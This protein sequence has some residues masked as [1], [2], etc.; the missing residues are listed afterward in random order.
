MGRAA[1]V[2]TYALGAHPGSYLLNARGSW[3][4]TQLL[5]RIGAANAELVWSM[6]GGYWNRD[7]CAVRSW[8]ER[9]AVEA[10]FIH[11]GGHAWPDDLERLTTALQP[12]LVEIVHT[13]KDERA[14]SVGLGTSGGRGET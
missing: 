12:R 6:W 8:A 2:G 4:T 11:S 10:H 1:R 5:N 13:A 14:T 9:E 7:D 3:R